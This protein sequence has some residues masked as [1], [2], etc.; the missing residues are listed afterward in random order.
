MRL[1]GEFWWSHGAEISIMD[2]ECSDGRSHVGAVIMGGLGVV[3]TGYLF[4]LSFSVFLIE[5]QSN[6]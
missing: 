3:N 6:R 2:C 4:F 5:R 1:A